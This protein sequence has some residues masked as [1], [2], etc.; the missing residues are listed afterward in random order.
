MVAHNL[1]QKSKHYPVICLYETRYDHHNYLW[2][3]KPDTIII[4]ISGVTDLPRYD[5]HNY[6]WYDRPTIIDAK[7]IKGL[8]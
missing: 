3:D 2:Y 6:L 7:Y 8:T 4:I 1:P 5:H